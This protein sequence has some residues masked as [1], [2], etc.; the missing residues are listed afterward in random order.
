LCGV[1]QPP[2]TLLT[3]SFNSRVRNNQMDEASAEIPR[4]IWMMWWQGFDTAPDLIKQ[5]CSSWERHNRDWKVVLLDKENLGEYLDMRNIVDINRRDISIQKMANLIRVNLLR[6]HGGVWVDATCFCCAPLDSWLGEYTTSGF[7]AFSDAGKGRLLSNWFLASAKDGY[8]ISKFCDEHNLF[9]NSACFSNQNTRRG[10]FYL[11]KLSKIIKR[12]PS[13]TRWWFSWPVLK[14][15][16]VYPY[17]IFHYHF[18]KIINE[19]ALFR[20]IWSDTK[21]YSA[22]IPHKVLF[23]GLHQPLSQEIRQFIDSRQSPLHKLTWKHKDN[24]YSKGCTLNYLLESMS[25]SKA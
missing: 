24:I 1:I 5:C 17:F 19:D 7:F 21:K 22:G 3:D 23:S 14:V 4:I 12:K 25:A 8:L 9:W 10:R 18:A 16:K 13:R 2:V 20:Q 6:K 11:K 15:F